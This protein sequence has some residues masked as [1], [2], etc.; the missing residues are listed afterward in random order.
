MFSA[1]RHSTRSNMFLRIQ[2]STRKQMPWDGLEKFGSTSV[3]SSVHWGIRYCSV[4][5]SFSFFPL[6][7]VKNWPKSF[8][9]KNCQKKGLHGI[10]CHRLVQNHWPFQSHCND[11]TGKNS[12][13]PLKNLIILYFLQKTRREGVHWRFE[14]WRFDKI[15]TVS[16]GHFWQ[17]TVLICCLCKIKLLCAE[18][19]LRCYSQKLKIGCL[20]SDILRCRVSN[21]GRLWWSFC[22]ILIIHGK[23]AGRTNEQINVIIVISGNFC[24]GQSFCHEK[25]ITEIIRR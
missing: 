11:M 18:T 20:F 6:I 19:L 8:F 1:A 3:K 22:K 23:V 14:Y 4:P 5:Q 13:C 7:S 12:F 2:P 16:D 24:F 15:S 25:G 10:V 9:N 21:L 17:T